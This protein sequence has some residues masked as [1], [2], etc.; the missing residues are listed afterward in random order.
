MC[1][2]DDRPLVSDQLSLVAS[3]KRIH[4]AYRIIRG[5]GETR[6]IGTFGTGV[7]NDAGVP[8]RC[9]GVASDITERRQAEDMLRRSQEQLRALS[10]RLQTATERE[11]LRIARELHDQFGRVLTGLKMDLDWIVRKHGAAGGLWVSLVQDSMK[12]VDSTIGLVRRLATELRPE[13]LDAFGLRAAVRWHA[14]QFQQRTGTACVFDDSDSLLRSV[15]HF[16]RLSKSESLY[17]PAPTHL[18]N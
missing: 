15:E 7:F 2:P 3:G 17:L 1:H 14:E 6:W 4:G 16:T 11:R 13:I 8:I 5:D 12:V 9:V 18:N 10:A